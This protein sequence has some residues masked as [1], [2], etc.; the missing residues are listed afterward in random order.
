MLNSTHTFSYENITRNRRT[1]I[2]KRVR[3]LDYHVLDNG[4]FIKLSTLKGR[5][6]HQYQAM[7]YHQLPDWKIHFSIHQ[8][9]LPKA[10]NIIA[11]IFLDMQCRSIMKMII[12]DY[13]GFFWPSSMRGREITVYIYQHSRF[14]E[15]LEPDAF[16]QL[17]QEDEHLRSYW[18]EFIQRAEQALAANNIR[19]CGLAIGDLSLENCH[20][21]SLRN[22]AYVKFQKEWNDIVPMGQRAKF[23]GEVFCY[24]PSIEGLYNGVC[25]PNPLASRS[26]CEMFSHLQYWSSANFLTEEQI[27]TLEKIYNEILPPN[28]ALKEVSESFFP[29]LETLRDYFFYANK[30]E[31]A[32]LCTLQIISALE[33]QEKYKLLENLYNYFLTLDPLFHYFYEPDLIIRISKKTVCREIEDY[34]NK[35]SLE[36]VVYKYPLPDPCV[37]MEC[38]GEVK[39]GIVHQNLQNFLSIFHEVAEAM[40]VLSPEAQSLYLNHVIEFSLTN[41]LEAANCLDKKGG[42][43]DGLAKEK[44][45]ESIKY[46]AF[47]DMLENNQEA[48][49]ITKA[50]Q[51]TNISEQ[52]NAYLQSHLQRFQECVDIGNISIPQGGNMLSLEQYSYVERIIHVAFNMAGYSRVEEGEHLA[53]LAADE[54]K[55]VASYESPHSH[56]IMHRL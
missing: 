21:A 17:L 43:L 46:V 36:Y 47:S 32:E 51:Q 27:E 15:K 52:E 9:D 44:L 3:H 33:P 7:Y 14:Y 55:L 54:F 1:L 50:I 45:T 29:R 5:F 41:N 8:E 24:P 39:D 6:Y 49:L 10:W 42:Y 25:H 23:N 35:L 31:S 20:Y 28:Q 38:Y 30:S 26:W 48:R 12:G 34:L 19:T 56:S 4:G 13:D 18:L 2:D 40:I 37:T 16:V 53:S 11:H 22:E